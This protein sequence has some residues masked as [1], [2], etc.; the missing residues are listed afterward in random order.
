LRADKD[1]LDGQDE[2][3]VAFDREII[4]DELSEKWMSFAEGVRIVVTVI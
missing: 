4:D 3:L 2:T 1:K